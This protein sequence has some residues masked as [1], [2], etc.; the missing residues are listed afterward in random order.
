ECER[1]FAK[2]WLFLGHESQLRKP[3]D[4]VTSYMAEDPI[5]LVRQRDGSV[6][7]FLNQCRH[8]GMR[9]CQAELGNARSF[10]CSYHGWNYDIS[11]DLKAVPQ[12]D[13]YPSCFKKSDWGARKVTRVESYKGLIFGT[14]SEDGPTL[15][16]YLG[17]ARFYLDGFV[18]RIEGGTEVAGGIHKWVINC[19]WKMA[20]EQFVSDMY[21]AASTHVSALQVSL[22]EDYDPGKHSMDERD[23]NQWWTEQGHGG[24]FFR[25]EEPNPPI[26]VDDLAQK[27]FHD[28]F[29]EACE[30][31][32]KLRAARTSGHTTIFPN[33][34]YLGGVNTIR[35]WHPRGPNQIEVWSW[36]LVDTVAPPEVK[37]A[38]RRSTQRN[39][40]PSGMLEQDDGENWVH[41]QRVLSGTIASQTE[42]CY[43]MGMDLETEHIEPVGPHATSVFADRASRNFYRKWQELLSDDGAA[44]NQK[45]GEKG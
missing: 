9:I 37:T 5:I 25:S 38:F 33:F 4:F 26:Y 35:V 2:C 14:W 7:A 34:S 16:E 43:Q 32:G 29:P 3:G 21:H 18:D 8:R 42:L 12:E 28:T 20:A 23:G 45:T 1:I 6:A 31:V 13:K 36:S 19:N 44:A 11:G 30:R 15:E 41:M 17:P 10:T 27:W 40:G 24:G 39:F 22:P